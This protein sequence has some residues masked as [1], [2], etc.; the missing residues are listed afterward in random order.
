MVKP[1][2]FSD[3]TS[4]TLSTLGRAR[5]ESLY[6]SVRCSNVIYG[7]AGKGCFT[8]GTRAS[9]LEGRSCPLGEGYP[10]N[11]SEIT[12]CRARNTSDRNS[13]ISRFFSDDSGGL[14]ED[15]S[16]GLRTFCLTAPSKQF[17]TL[18][19]GKRCVFVEGDIP[20]LDSMYVPCRSWF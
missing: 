18:G 1:D 12:T 17:R 16:G 4:T 11:A 5:G 15:G 3:A 19:G 6:G 14:M 13:C 9:G 2:G 20:K 8:S 10:A 7:S